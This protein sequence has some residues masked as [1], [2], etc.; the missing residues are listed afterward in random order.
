MTDAEL[1]A[2]IAAGPHDKVTKEGIE[3]RIK[4]VGYLVLP[5][6]TCTI[7]SIELDNGFGVRGES[8]CVDKRNFNM[9]T[10]EEISYRNAFSKLWEL[11][12]YLLAE[13]KHLASLAAQ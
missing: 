9:K 10:G 4:R 11:E 1:D 12:G 13:R 8:A 5:G 6:T 7:C 2:A 3:A